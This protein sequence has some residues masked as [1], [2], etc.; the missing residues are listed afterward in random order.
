MCGR[1]TMAD[2][3]TKAKALLAWKQKNLQ[4]DS[5]ISKTDLS[6]YFAS[7]FMVIA[8]DR[9]YDANYDNYLDFLNTFK[10]K[11][12]QLNHEVYEYLE[13]ENAVT[14]PMRASIM[15]KNEEEKHYEAVMILTFNENGKIIEWRE[16]CVELKN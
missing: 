15:Y 14:M 2:L 8:N 6:E 11:I 4:S 9:H 13:S 16:V 1:L 7:E 5:C 12:K 10:E 3:I